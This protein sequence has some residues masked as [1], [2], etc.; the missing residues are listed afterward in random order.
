V[1][2]CVHTSAR[3]RGREGRV[4]ELLIAP[5][6]GVVE[7]V[8]ELIGNGTLAR[9]DTMRCALEIWVNGECILKWRVADNAPAV[10]RDG[11]LD[12]TR[13]LLQVARGSPPEHAPDLGDGLEGMLSAEAIARGGA[14]E[15]EGAAA[16]GR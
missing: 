15:I 13:A 5:N 12:E 8:Y 14:E 11:T 10:E 7:E 16:T 1:E 3:I 6:A 9:V 2:G 4:A